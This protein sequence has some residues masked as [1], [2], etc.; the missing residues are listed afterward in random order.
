MA[1]HLLPGKPVTASDW[2]LKNLVQFVNVMKYCGDDPEQLRL[3][4]ENQSIPLGQ[5]QPSQSA[6]LEN[7]EEKLE[8]LRFIAN[9]SFVQYEGE[10]ATRIDHISIDRFAWA[11]IWAAP[12]ETLKKWKAT[13]VNGQP[14]AFD[15]MVSK[16]KSNVPSL[17]NICKAKDVTNQTDV[18]RK[19][20]RKDAPR[21]TALERDGYRCSLLGSHDPQVAHIYPHASILSAKR[22]ISLTRGALMELWGDEPIR[23]FMDCMKMNHI[24][25]AQNMISLSCQIHFAMD[26]FKIAL[27][28]LWAN[29]NQLVV[30]V[31]HLADSSLRP[32]RGQ[33]INDAFVSLNT[34]PKEV[35]R[36]LLTPGGEKVE[37][38][39]RHVQSGQP[40]RDGH[41]FSITTDNPDIRPLPSIDIMRV[42]YHMALMIRLAGAAEDD[43]DDDDDDDPP[44]EST[45]TSA[46]QS[47]VAPFDLDPLWGTE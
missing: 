2:K 4:N 1:H 24:D 36:D 10:E 26:H 23:K 19:P 22:C 43:D 32:R 5:L 33:K 18:N 6:F 9:T 3:M 42:S 15:E 8:I 27:E 12:L 25:V 47:D 17:I 35:L 30:R 28:P 34:D 41:V 14:L 37:L 31:R 16:L 44:E 29:S 38:D 11:A 45:A 7:H 13:I 21:Q 20:P 39:A 40:I 46:S